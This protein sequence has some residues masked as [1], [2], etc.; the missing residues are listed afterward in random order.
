MLS[1]VQYD[2]LRNLVAQ[3][4]HDSLLQ[5]ELY[6]HLCCS[7]E[8]KIGQGLAF[9]SALEMAVAELG[10]GKLS[11]IESQTV[12][13]LTLTNSYPMKKLIYL[14]GFL[15][16]VLILLGL[17]FKTMHWPE[18]SLILLLGNLSLLGCMLLLLAKKRKFS[19][20]IPALQTYLSIMSG[21]LIA[22]GSIF[23][24]MHWPSANIQMISGMFLLITLVVPAY[25][26][27]LYKDSLL[28]T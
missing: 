5:H 21:I 11:E 7:V 24:I 18:A 13:L 27:K 8:V 15:A 26:W 22:I 17:V 4:V 3:S 16:T 14:S 12:F 6:D 1:E 20:V 25:F 10:P 23:K 9:E 2:T 19:S 28:T